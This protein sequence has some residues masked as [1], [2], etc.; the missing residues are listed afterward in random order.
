MPSFSPSFERSFR[1]RFFPE[2]TAADWA[3]ARWQLAHR[4]RTAERLLEVLP[5]LL[6][7]QRRAL[8]RA[9]TW[10]MPLLLTPYAAALL[11]SLP[12]EHPYRRTLLPDLREARVAA[13][14]TRDPL[15][16]LPHLVAPGLVHAY[17]TKALLL[18]TAD[19]ASFCRYCTR[20]R[21]ACEPPATDFGP[22]FAYLRAHPEIDDVLV[23]G[24]DPLTLPDAVLK[25]LLD[26]LA[27]IPSVT[28]LRIGTKVPAMLP[29]RVTP[30]LVR[31]LR[32]YRPIW[33]SL[34]FSHPAE[35][36]GRAAAALRRLSDSGLPLMNQCVLLRG[37]NDDADVLRE[38]FARLIRLNVKPYYLHHADQAA[39]TGH[40]RT[41]MVRGR[42][43]LR[44][45]APRLT[46]YAVPRYMIDPYPGGL[47]HPID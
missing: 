33:L 20:A 16:E 29:Q 28:F 17:P 38:L 15:G 37:V 36:T 6:P 42:A 46:G 12:A 30:A 8:A 32:R 41:P 43:L 7:A 19:C 34:H 22:A 31:L 27:A 44:Q 45:I 13:G 35:L 3:D 21:T 40:F 25:R 23:S 10:R 11:A 4:I 1:T 18:A 14:D 26:G 5:D 9:E 24:G 39:G 47:Q 2:A